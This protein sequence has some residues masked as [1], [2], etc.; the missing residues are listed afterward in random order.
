MSSSSRST[1]ANDRLKAR[2]GDI[3]AVAFMVA[4]LSHFLVFQMW[5]EMTVSDWT[6]PDALP[7]DIIDLASVPLPAPPPRITRPALPV[8]GADVDPTATIAVMDFQRV[9]ELPPPPPRPAEGVSGDRFVVVYE[10]APRLTNPEEFQRALARAYPASL[11]DAGIGGTVTLEVFVDEQ[12]RA[13]EGRVTDGSGYAGLDTAAMSLIDV[14][15]F[16]PALNRD[17]TVAVWVR[18]PIEFRSRRDR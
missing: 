12:G 4:T 6:S 7:L 5:P 13:R 2:F 8:I 11:R 3:V 14:M 16:S 18:L 15:R 10:V 1:S 17:R 9:K